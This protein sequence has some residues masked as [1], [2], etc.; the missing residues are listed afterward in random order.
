M[1]QVCAYYFNL[2]VVVAYLFYFLIQLLF[3]SFKI[4]I[5]NNS[6]KADVYSWSMVTYELLTLQ[7]PF[8]VGSIEQHKKAICER[9]E[10]PPLGHL[11]WLDTSVKDLLQHSWQADVNAR[12]HMRDIKNSLETIIAD[13]EA[14]K[15]FRK[16]GSFGSFGYGTSKS[17]DGKESQSFNFCQSSGMTDMIL[18]FT[19]AVQTRYGEYLFCSN[20]TTA[21]STAASTRTVADSEAAIAPSGK[22]LENCATKNSKPED[23]PDREISLKSYQNTAEERSLR[24]D[25]PET[26][27]EAADRLKD[28]K[29]KA[30]IPTELESNK[31]DEKPAAVKTPTKSQGDDFYTSA[32]KSLWGGFARPHMSRVMRAPTT[33]NTSEQDFSERSLSM[34]SVRLQ[35]AQTRRP[36]QNRRPTAWVAPRRLTS[37]N[38][39][40]D[41]GRASYDEYGRARPYASRSLRAHSAKLDA[42]IE[43]ENEDEEDAGT[44]MMFEN[45]LILPSI[46]LGG[47][48]Q[49]HLEEIAEEAGSSLRSTATPMGTQSGASSLRSTS[50]PAPSS[51]RSINTPIPSDCA[52]EEIIESG[53]AT[54]EAPMEASPM[55]LDPNT[56]PVGS[57]DVAN[58]N[59]ATIFNDDEGEEGFGS[60]A[61]GTSTRIKT[62]SAPQKGPQDEDKDTPDGSAVKDFIVATASV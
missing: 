10:R 45:S 62:C 21:A 12:W 19:N 60:I 23:T 57:R 33:A 15:G 36:A 56:A 9:G 18:D 31:Q 4:P 50:T 51:L 20:D 25:I 29:P 47:N 28:K 14:R 53:D 11:R 8:A 42:T 38:Q 52:E 54:T 46:K 17:A 55:T 3:P 48:G 6:Q 1:L 41:H 13:L 59:A 2:S 49:E 61:L 30:S 27:K 37:V 26:K 24:F 7:K 35:E 39:S 43:L 58:N 32:K 34:H 5:H 44:T 16:D 40:Q 22:S